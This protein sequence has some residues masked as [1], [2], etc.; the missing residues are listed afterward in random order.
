MAAKKSTRKSFDMASAI[1]LLEQA[2]KQAGRSMKRSS[3]RLSLTADAA[4][5]IAENDKRAD[6]V[7]NMLHMSL[8]F[9][10]VMCSKSCLMDFSTRY[11]LSIRT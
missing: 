8:Y 10:C 4:R 5:L 9:C 11:C 2:E 6:R 1:P 7:S 3:Q